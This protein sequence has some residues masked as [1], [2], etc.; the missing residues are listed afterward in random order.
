MAEEFAGERTEEA[1]PRRKQEARR[2]GT[3]AKSTDLNGAVLIVILTL[4][5]PILLRYSSSEFT[6]AT[7]A[8]LTDLPTTISLP[9][10][11]NYIYKILWPGLMLGLPIVLVALFAGLVTNFAQVGFVLSPE[12]LKPSFERINPLGGFKRL[13]SPRAL[14]EALKSV[15]KAMLFGY[16]VW[17]VIR[18][19]WQTILGLAGLHP[20][21]GVTLVG[22][23][24]VKIFLYVGIFWLVLG[25][26]DYYF[27]YKQVSKQLRMSKDELKREMREQEVS[28][29]LRGIQA[30]RR[31][32]LLKGRLKDQV[33]KADVV[34]TN[35][36][37]FAV[38]LKY[39]R[40]KMHAPVV[41]A[42]GHGYLALKIREIAEKH[43]V[44]IVPNPPLAR[45]LY[46]KCEL[47]DYIPRNLYKAVAE[48]LAY[49]YTTVKSVQQ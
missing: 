41:I 35:P 36:S 48:I 33:P 18:A 38:A 16:I 39:E 26:F 34:I 23:L 7:R 1:T 29:E 17:Y 10:F 19:E 15:V 31:K 32:K 30:Q 46:K 3:V 9:L 8:V 49:V 6:K 40:N 27:Q 14:V 22:N 2:K 25:A 37:H 5:T 44:P 24:I 45:E 43:R 11:V 13:F 28:P 20:L 21:M 12:A 42:K 4:V 47:G